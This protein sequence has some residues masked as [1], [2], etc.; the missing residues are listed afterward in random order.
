MN[1]ACGAE[2][3]N[4]TAARDTNAAFLKKGKR[5][6]RDAKLRVPVSM[7]FADASD[8]AIHNP[9]EV[10]ASYR[11]FI[12]EVVAQFRALP[13]K[14]FP[15]LHDGQ[16]Y[17][18]SG[19][20]CERVETTGTLYVFKDSVTG[21]PLLEGHPLAERSGFFWN[22]EGAR[23]EFTLNEVF[24][25]VHDFRSHVLPRHSFGPV[26]EFRAA[27]VHSSELSAEALPALL[28]E[29][30]VQ[31]AWFNFGAHLRD[32]NGAVIQR[33]QPGYIAPEERPFAIQKAFKLAPE[34]VNA[35]REI[36]REER[37]NQ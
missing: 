27:L 7:A 5:M 17:S 13:V 36:L 21:S 19:E 8:A 37:G 25:A 6:F 16:P 28:C 31:N 10:A 24:R 23:G 15:W 18:T 34:L 26:G 32:A 33:G 3:I 4:F 22:C 20:L 1:A 2:N 29:T 9:A 12:G 14:V 35:W 30:Q 11:A